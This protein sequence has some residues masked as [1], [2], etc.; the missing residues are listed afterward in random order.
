[1]RDLKTSR[2]TRP[3]DKPRSKLV[4]WARDGPAKINQEEPSVSV[5]SQNKKRIFCSEDRKK[6]SEMFHRAPPERPFPAGRFAPDGM[7][8]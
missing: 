5:K 6:I 8:A 4:A 3:S 1:L 2:S 7:S